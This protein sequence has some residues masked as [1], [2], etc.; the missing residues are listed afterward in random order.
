MAR[1]AGL[2]RKFLK[3]V[4]QAGAVRVVLRG[5]YQRADE[6]DDQTTRS[7]AAFLVLG[8]LGVLADRTAA[9]L[10]GV[11]TF[12]YRELDVLP[13]L[14]MWV[15]R[16]GSRVRRTGC[17]GGERDLDVEDVMT[18]G[19]TRVTTPLRTALDLGCRLSRREALAALDGFMREHGLTQD[20]YRGQLHRYF[21]RR[22]VVQLRQLVA[23][24]DG[25]AE[26]AAE[27]WTRLCIIDDGLPTPEIQHWVCHNGREVYRLDLAYPERRVA[28][29]YDG[30][31]YHDSPA[32]VAYDDQRRE[33]LRR[34]GWTVIVVRKDSFGADALRR[35]LDE[36][37]RVLAFPS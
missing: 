35:W 33:W 19:R 4:V 16:D 36:L 27:S 17:V 18:V 8:P 1:E 25:R 28:I 22:G 7:Q 9:W 29:E 5:V 23:R 21:R 20:D 30:R 37:R 6:P 2:G 15:L 13:P 12:E 32:Q 34:R 14:E 3:G 26:S 24:A 31:Q 10:H 11:D